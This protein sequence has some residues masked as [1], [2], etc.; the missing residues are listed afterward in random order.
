LKNK[1]IVTSTESLILES[2]KYAKD[3]EFYKDYYFKSLKIDLLL[4]TEKIGSIN[5]IYKKMDLDAQDLKNFAQG[6]KKENNLVLLLSST[7]GSKV[8]ITLLISNNLISE[9]YNAKDLINILSKEISGGGGGQ[10]YIA[11]AGGSNFNGLDNTVKKVKEL[12][13]KKLA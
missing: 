10:D 7:T 2:K 12:F 8:L 3:L 5:F 9:G 11:T 1:N 13:T 6:F 4:N